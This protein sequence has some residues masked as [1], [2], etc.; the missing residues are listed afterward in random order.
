MLDYHYDDEPVIVHVI[1]GRISS[2]PEK[3]I[4][5]W[6]A[7]ELRELIWK[8]QVYAHRDRW[9]PMIRPKTFRI[10]RNP[11]RD[12]RALTI[13]LKS[14]PERHDDIPKD[15]ALAV[16]GFVGRLMFDCVHWQKPYLIEIGAVT[17]GTT[18]HPG[19]GSLEIWVHEPWQGGGPQLL[20]NT[21]MTF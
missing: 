3:P 13:S 4:N 8:L 19:L 20:G 16:A 15:V 11:A 10:G 21:T 12:Q 2:P 18:K 14:G 17:F 6:E 5:P 1:T 7:T 9:N